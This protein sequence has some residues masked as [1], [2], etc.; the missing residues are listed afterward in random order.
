M[1]EMWKEFEF[2]NDLSNGMYLVCY[3]NE[4]DN[5]CYIEMLFWLNAG[6]VVDDDVLGGKI[7]HSLPDSDFVWLNYALGNY[8]RRV[9]EKS[10]FYDWDFT[11]DTEEW[12]YQKDLFKNDIKYIKLT[13]DIIPFNKKLYIPSETNVG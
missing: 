5:D 4:K 6:T 12:K 11:R 2:D 1:K 7:A 8:N 10:G 13:N 9:I 3:S